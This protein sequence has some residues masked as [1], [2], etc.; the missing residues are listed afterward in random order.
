MHVEESVFIDVFACILINKH[1]A[2]SDS[3]T[4]NHKPG[5]EQPEELRLLASKSG[6]R[7]IIAVKKNRK[8]K[9][10]EVS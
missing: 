10:K 6:S 2:V 5:N 1:D 7:L 4:N 3:V 9:V 8:I